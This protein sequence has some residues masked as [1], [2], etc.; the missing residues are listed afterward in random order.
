VLQYRSQAGAGGEAGRRAR[1]EP[2]RGP[3]RQRVEKRGLGLG[4]RGGEVVEKLDDFR[5]GNPP[6]AREPRVGSALSSARRKAVSM[7]SVFA[8]R[9]PN[10]I[11][12]RSRG[13]GNGRTESRRMLR[14]PLGRVLNYL[15]EIVAVGRR[16]DVPEHKSLEPR[17]LLNL[18]L[19]LGQISPVL[20]Q[21]DHDIIGYSFRQASIVTV[22]IALEPFAQA[23]PRLHFGKKALICDARAAIRRAARMRRRAQEGEDREKEEQEAK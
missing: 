5:L 10:H 3:D 11:Q 19:Q 22:R 20:G 18:A 15:L 7:A 14:A 13:A 21:G 6:Q 1:L 8:S 17:I 4:G 2:D 12:S 16:I 9:M 23:R